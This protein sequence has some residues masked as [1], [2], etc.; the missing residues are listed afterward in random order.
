[1]EKMIMEDRIA[2]ISN[3]APHYWRKKNPYFSETDLNSSMI[4][5][6]TLIQGQ[7]LLNGFQ[8][9]TA[10]DYSKRI[11]SEIKDFQLEKCNFEKL[12]FIFDLIQAWG[13]RTG[14]SPYVKRNGRAK[15]SR[16]CFQDWKEH[17]LDGIRFAVSGDPVSALSRWRA[18]FGLGSSFAPKHLMFWSGTYPVLDSRI[19]LL[20][21][22]SK[23]LL[24]S[25]SGYGEFLSLMG[26]L[27][28]Q[29]DL[30]FLEVEKALFAFSQNFFMNDKLVFR[31]DMFSDVTDLEIAE[32]LICAA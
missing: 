2:L 22:G 8:P 5:A 10:A 1:M 9:S 19:S 12:A 18:I 14:R 21:C 11:K 29:W 24:Q 23:R 17:Y 25:P 26:P 30:N 32:K 4:S 7:G 27:C 20:L 16:E 6:L 13:G 28:I 15:T 31:K 3:I